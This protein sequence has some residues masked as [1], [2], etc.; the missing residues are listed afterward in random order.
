[1]SSLDAL[2]TEVT[3]L[4]VKTASFQLKVALQE[5]DPRLAQSYEVCRQAALSCQRTINSQDLE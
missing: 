2:T 1:M 3:A 5:A 4:R